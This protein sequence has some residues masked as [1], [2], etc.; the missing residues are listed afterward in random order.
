MLGDGLLRAVPWGLNLALCV[1]AL[2][3]AAALVVRRHRRRVGPDAPWLALTA[4]LLGAASLRRASEALAFFDVVALAL[5]LA[6]GLRSAQGVR[7][8]ALG[9]AQHLR[10]LADAAVHA[11]TGAVRLLW[12]DISW[13]EA[14]GEG[15]LG[16]LRAVTLGV[17]LAAPVVVLFGAL[18]AS[19]DAVFANLVNRVFRIEASTVLEHAALWA[20]CAGVT[21][22]YLN[23][24]LQPRPRQ[25]GPAAGPGPFLGIVPVG[26]ALGLVNLLFLLFVVIQLRYLFGGEQVV[27]QTTGLTFA[28]YARRGFFELVAVSGLSLPL[29]LG[30]DWAIRGES[31]AGRRTFRW[32]AGLTLALL[33]VVMASALER[34]RLYVAEF[35][36]SEDRLYATAFMVYLFGLFAWFGWTVLRGRRRGFAFGGLIQGLAV[37]AGLHLLNPDAVIAGVNLDRAAAGHRFDGPYL[38]SLSADAVPVLLRRLPKLAPEA[39]CEVAGRLLERWGNPES[40]GDWRSWNWSRARARQLVAAREADLRRLAAS[41]PCGSP[42][43]AP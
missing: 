30:A 26:V 19:A 22:G 36:L 9:V 25:A 34:M 37:L 29:L 21:A 28:E 1:G 14:L 17:G 18:F 24:L 10:A 16:R 38:T 27:L 40:V 12:R 35:G 2:V 31:F 23:G 4:L 11:A 43:P 5:V 33:L 6:L 7:V 3:G 8:A 41:P 20:A 13:R 15:R 42:H 39:R 32:L